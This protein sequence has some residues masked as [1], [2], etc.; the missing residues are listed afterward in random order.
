[1]Y[2]GFSRRRAETMKQFCMKK[3]IISQR[4]E[5]VLIVFALQHGGNDV[6]WECSIV[7]R[8]YPSQRAFMGVLYMGG[9][10]TQGGIMQGG[11]GKRGGGKDS[12]HLRLV[13]KYAASVITSR[14]TRK[15][16]CK[17]GRHK[18]KRKSKKKENVSLLNAC[19]APVY[20][21]FFWCLCLCL[22]RTCEPGFTV[23]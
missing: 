22:R 11:G 12:Q 10:Y 6:T 8:D 4:R 23:F 19:I 15:S 9:D 13:H 7:P 14:S 18:L 5:N 1:M 3:D 21:Y 2:R 20:T 17:P 16:M